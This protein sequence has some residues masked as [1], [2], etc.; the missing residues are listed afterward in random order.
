MTGPIGSGE[1][2]KHGST[3]W[4]RGERKKQGEQNYQKSLK[5]CL[6]ELPETLGRDFVGI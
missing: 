1:S 4:G 6:R 3:Q 2:D 5:R